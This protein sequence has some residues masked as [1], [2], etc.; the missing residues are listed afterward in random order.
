MC[1]VHSAQEDYSFPQFPTLYSSGLPS[2][3]RGSFGRVLEI[4]FL[5]G[6]IQITFRCNFTLF[7]FYRIFSNDRIVFPNVYLNLHL[8]S[9]SVYHL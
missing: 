8:E 9:F 2:I 7:F 5:L 4:V 6:L 1:R 3:Y